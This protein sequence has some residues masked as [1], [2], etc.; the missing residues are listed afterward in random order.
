MGRMT[1]RDTT[2]WPSL[3]ARDAHQLIKFLVDVIGF[4]PAAL[5]GEGDVVQH[6]QLNWPEGGGVMLGSV[7]EEPGNPWDVAP[8]SSGAYVATDHVDEIYQR[9]VA[10]G[11]RIVRELNDTDYGSHEFAC[12]DPEGNLWS[13]GTY[14]PALE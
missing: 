6:C 5:Y 13:F 10:A 1:S 7:R 8:G 12:R 11:G 4:R 3:R 14:R 9:V 2:V